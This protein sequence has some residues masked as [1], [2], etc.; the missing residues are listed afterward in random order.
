VK[1]TAFEW[2]DKAKGKQKTARALLPASVHLTLGGNKMRSPMT[3]TELRWRIDGCRRSRSWSNAI[4]RLAMA[5]PFPLAC[6]G[7]YNEKDAVADALPKQMSICPNPGRTIAS[8]RSLGDVGRSHVS[9]HRSLIKLVAGDRVASSELIECS[10]QRVAA[11]SLIRSFCRCGY[12]CPF[13]RR[14]RRT[15]R[16]MR[17]KLRLCFLLPRPARMAR[18]N[19]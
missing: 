19:S 16:R 12:R 9:T 15:P 11:D 10:Q 2:K 14:V 13:A 8:G 1:A 3:I 6:S 17:S 7:I 5:K 18:I 4:S